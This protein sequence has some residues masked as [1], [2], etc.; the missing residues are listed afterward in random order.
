MLRTNI[1]IHKK[2]LW[3]DQF[4][5]VLPILGHRNWIVVADSAY[6]LQTGEGMQIISTRA[7]HL[8]VLTEVLDAV[9]S[10]A[11]IRPDVYLDEELSTMRDSMAEGTEALRHEVMNLCQPYPVHLM[12]HEKIIERLQN[13]SKDFKVIVLK[14]NCV[15]PYTSVF[16][17]LECGYWTPENEKLLRTKMK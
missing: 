7:D 2:P 10:A 17:Q 11:H 8:H 13:A 5:E 1:S 14:T 4:D 3:K 6:P 9:E 12:P 16:L 15:I